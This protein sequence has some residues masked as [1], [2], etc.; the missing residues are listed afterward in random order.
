[1][2]EDNV[3]HVSVEG[4]WVSSFLSWSLVWWMVSRSRGARDAGE[5]GVGTEG[6][7]RV[8]FPLVALQSS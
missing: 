4:M 5:V 3:E 1:M 6:D 7:G 8:C 2:R